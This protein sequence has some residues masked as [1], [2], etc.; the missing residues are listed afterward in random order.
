MG[1]PAPAEE[2]VVSAGVRGWVLAE[3]QA[4]QAGVRGR[5]LAE[6]PEWVPAVEQAEVLVG[7]QVAVPVQ[8]G[9][10][11]TQQVAR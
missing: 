6:E 11:A 4:E 7:W 10:P 1:L 8:V 9:R 2:P 5:V 3:E